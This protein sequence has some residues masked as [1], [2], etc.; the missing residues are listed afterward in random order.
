[1]TLGIKRQNREELSNDVTFMINL[2]CCQC[3]SQKTVHF[4]NIV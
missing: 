1:M 4:N 3:S 2:R